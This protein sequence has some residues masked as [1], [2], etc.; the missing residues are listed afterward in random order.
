MTDLQG[1]SRVKPR[2]GDRADRRSYERAR[3]WTSKAQ[4]HSS[5]PVMTYDEFRN[6]RYFRAIDG[7]RAVSILLVL[8]W[9]VNSTLWGWLSGWEGVSI[10]FV[11]SGFLITTLCLREEARD[12]SVSLKAFYIRRTCRIFPLYFLVLG[13]YV[14][15]IIGLNYHAQRSQLVRSLPYYLTYMND[16]SPYL[17][18]AATPF[19]ASWS[20]GVEEKFYLIWPVLAFFILRRPRLRVVAAC[21]L[22]LVTF[23]IHDPRNLYLHYSQI[24]VGCL[25]ALLLHNRAIFSRLRPI[26]Q[27]HWLLL[28]AF[29]TVHFLMYQHSSSAAKLVYGPAVALMMG[30]VVVAR[31]LWAKPLETRTMIYIGQR[32]YGVYL[33]QM[34]CLSVAISTTRHVWPSAAFNAKT[35]PTGN[36]AWLLSILLLV[37]GTCASLLVA[38]ILHR[39]VERPMI[40]RGRVWS[41]AVTG[42]RPVAPPRMTQ[43]YE[44]EVA[45]EAAKVSH[46]RGLTGEAGTD[47]AGL[48]GAAHPTSRGH[49]TEPSAVSR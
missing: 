4:R 22:I 32:S 2:S 31:P 6:D 30:A 37:V 28:I 21:L 12:G 20:L 11:I 42:R 23:V 16:L 1:D 36:G 13:L 7:L 15:L 38:E 5:P 14:V 26:F 17:S 9:H 47:A 48:H 10:F 34:M 45:E 43:E 19:T 35:E 39:T 33:I 46:T 3:S 41:A 8:T 44:R 49:A 24:M 40:A 25:L 18:D 29:V 27:W